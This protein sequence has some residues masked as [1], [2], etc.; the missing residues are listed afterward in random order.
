MEIIFEILRPTELRVGPV[1]AFV[2][3]E[4][5]ERERTR[6]LQKKYQRYTLY[7][8]LQTVGC[9]PNPVCHLLLQN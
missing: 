8:G 6:K 7:L 2:C 1:G 5:K 4:V 9:R 3:E